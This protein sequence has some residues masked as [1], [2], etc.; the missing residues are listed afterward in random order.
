MGVQTLKAAA[1]ANVTSGGTGSI[2]LGWSAPSGKRYLGNVQFKDGGGKALG[3][4]IVS[5]NA[6]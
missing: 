2:G 1:P 4:T 3:S 5:V 6:L